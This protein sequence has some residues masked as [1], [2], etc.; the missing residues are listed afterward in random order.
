MNGRP[1]LSA[2]GSI[3][4]G[5]PGMCPPTL[6]LHICAKYEDRMRA[7]SSRPQQPLI[8]DVSCVG[9][10]DVRKL[11]PS[12]QFGTTRPKSSPDGI[13]F[14]DLQEVQGSKGQAP[15]S[16]KSGSLLA[17]AIDSWQVERQLDTVCGGKMSRG[18]R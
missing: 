11:S 16:S 3:G 13:C 1:V 5:F 12:R 9:C 2:R 18:G 15:K 8:G 17:F 7:Q 4:N 6:H 14:R 10:S